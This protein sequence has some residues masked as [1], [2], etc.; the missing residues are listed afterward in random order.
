MSSKGSHST[1][2]DIPR[3]GVSGVLQLWLRLAPGYLPAA[4]PKAGAHG[5]LP[6]LAQACLLEEQD[7]ARQVHHRLELGIEG[8]HVGRHQNEA[9]LRGARGLSLSRQL[10]VVI[11]HRGSLGGTALLGR[12]LTLG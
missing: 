8:G 11:F 4:V 3:R 12:L 9:V 5:T 2:G 7:G 1:R 10:S 6:H